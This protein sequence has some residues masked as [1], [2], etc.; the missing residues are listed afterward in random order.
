M[1]EAT[2]ESNIPNLIQAFNNPSLSDR[3]LR[4]VLSNDPTLTTIEVPRKGTKRRRVVNDDP[5]NDDDAKA[6]DKSTAAPMSLDDSTD[7]A[8]MSSEPADK[9]KQDQTDQKD[10][11]NKKKLEAE[12]AVNTV[13]LCSHSKVFQRMLLDVPMKEASSTKAEPLLITV[14]SVAEQKRHIEMI[15]FFY[16]GK[17]RKETD[18]KDA[19]ELLLLADRFDA[20]FLVAACIDVLR[21][22]MTVD[23]AGHVL[24]S[25]HGLVVSDNLRPIIQHA[26]TFLTRRFTKI[27]NWQDDIDKWPAAVIIAVFS[28]DDL[29]VPCEELVWM[30]VTHWISKNPNSV[31][32]AAVFHCIRLC[33][34]CRDF[35]RTQVLSRL[36]S[37]HQ[38]FGGLNQQS[39]IDSFQKFMLPIQQAACFHSLPYGHLD[40]HR[41]PVAYPVKTLEYYGCKPR[42]GYNKPEQFK[43]FFELTVDNPSTYPLPS[44]VDATKSP[45]RDAREWKHLM[46]ERISYCLADFGGNVC[47]VPLWASDIDRHRLHLDLFFCYSSSH[48]V[49]REAKTFDFTTEYHWKHRPACEP[50]VKT[51]IQDIYVFTV[52]SQ[53]VSVADWRSRK[54]RELFGDHNAPLTIRIDCSLTRR[55]WWAS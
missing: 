13:T 40:N 6:N 55:P 17:L 25:L 53:P 7:D 36:V 31:D 43:T 51:V 11:T 27:K 42:S 29:D 9:A 20:P 24:S 48:K 1:T 47:I 37:I 23:T 21:V 19:M 30:L 18:Y 32:K 28:S 14:H 54:P 44:A 3:V 12:L 33:N 10:Q 49:T 41:P 35:F 2:R 52:W 8:N 45:S 34:L 50:H 22:D 15:E 38:E 16:S 5:A 39:S 46:G 4:F 26:T